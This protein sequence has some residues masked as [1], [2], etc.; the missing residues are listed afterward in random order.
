ML[1][2]AAALL[3][4]YSL[5]LCPSRAQ[6]DTLELWIE[7]H[8][9]RKI[10][11][12]T[13]DLQLVTKGRSR[14][15]LTS[16]SQLTLPEHKDS[17]RF[18]WQAPPGYKYSIDQLMTS[19]DSGLSSPY[20][21]IPH[22]GEVPHVESEFQLWLPCEDSDGDMKSVYMSLI[23]TNPDVSHRHFKP[24]TMLINKRCNL[25]TAIPCRHTCENGG[26]CGKYG[27]C[28]CSE[29]YYGPACK[30]VLCVPHCYNS[31]TC[32]KPGVC[33]CAE[34]FSG[35]ICEKASC[36]KNCSNHGRCIGPDKCVCHKQWTGKYCQK[37]LTS[38]VY[39]KFYKMTRAKRKST[40]TA[41]TAVENK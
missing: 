31:G 29:G 14:H 2:S 13:T 5:L 16:E 41:K 34:G 3:V 32:I 40:K 25:G 18:K 38:E 6:D 17:L 33:A 24:V 23:F 26:S 19:G 21:S 35:K 39:A 20:L 28:E 30:Q 36:K 27:V 4:M 37:R 1:V 11:G 12:A 10:S 9:M 22:A 7:G 15:F 8:E